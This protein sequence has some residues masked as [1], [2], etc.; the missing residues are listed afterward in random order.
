MVVVVMMLAH[1]CRGLDDVLVMVDDPVTEVRNF[2][3]CLR[4][5]GG[6]VTLG[7]A[8]VVRSGQILIG[9]ALGLFLGLVLVLVILVESQTK[10]RDEHSRLLGGV[11]LTLI[12]V[13]L[14]Q[15]NG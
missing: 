6:L 14:P 1:T 8:G 2:L 13:W 4:D 11:L 5:L 3:A 15:A 12:L 7:P 9:R 10:P